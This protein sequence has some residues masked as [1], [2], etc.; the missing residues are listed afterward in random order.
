MRRLEGKVAV[1]T[2]AA[3]G[4]GRATAARFAGEGAN[5][6]IADVSGIPDAVAQVTGWF[7]DGKG[8]G[9]TGAELPVE[10]RRQLLC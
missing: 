1:I 5:V 8:G 6:V 10:M 4:M 3:S 9:R 2:G 7:P